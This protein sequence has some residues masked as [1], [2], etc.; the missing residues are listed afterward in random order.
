MCDKVRI[1]VAFNGGIG[2]LIRAEELE[3]RLKHRNWKMRGV[4][5]EIFL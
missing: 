4:K 2:R 5:I 3:D 1:V